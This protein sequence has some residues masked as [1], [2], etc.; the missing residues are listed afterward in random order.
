MVLTMQEERKR[1]H[2]EAEWEGQHGLQQS[3]VGENGVEV[4]ILEWISHLYANLKID[5]SVW[6]M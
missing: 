3:D 2:S 5:N 1:T 4:I 6:M